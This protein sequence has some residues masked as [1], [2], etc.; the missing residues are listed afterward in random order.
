MAWQVRRSRSGCTRVTLKI[1]YQ[2]TA[3][4]EYTLRFSPDHQ[5]INAMKNAR[6]IKTHFASSQLHLWQRGETEWLLAVKQP[7][8]HPR[9]IKRARAGVVQLRFPEMELWWAD[10][11]S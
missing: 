9:K 10:T 1:E 3:L 8:R 6:R 4:S 5:Q 11:G 7:K 2:T